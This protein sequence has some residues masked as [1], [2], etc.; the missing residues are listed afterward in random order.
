MQ[1]RKVEA[2]ITQLLNNTQKIT[3][4]WK[5]E[6]EEAATNESLSHK[7]DLLYSRFQIEFNS[8]IQGYSLSNKLNILGDF[9]GTPAFFKKLQDAKTRMDLTGQTPFDLNTGNPIN[10]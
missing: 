4:K 3:T 1:I 7:A 6:T 8:L 9:A 2:E 10:E 5:K